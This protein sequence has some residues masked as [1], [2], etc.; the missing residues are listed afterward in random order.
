[1]LENKNT[2]NTPI[3]DICWRK[4]ITQRTAIAAHQVVTLGLHG[5]FSIATLKCSNNKL[6]RMLK[7][8]TFAFFFNFPAVSTI[9]D[10]LITI[11]VYLKAGRFCIGRQQHLSKV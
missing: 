5:I 3:S 10:N 1:M 6:L 2:G 4:H 11:W 7:K 8:A 9:L